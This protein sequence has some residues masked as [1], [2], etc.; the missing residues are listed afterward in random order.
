MGNFSYLV[1]DTSSVAINKDTL[2]KFRYLRNK[3]L[4]T[5]GESWP[6]SR[7]ADEVNFS[8]SRFCNIYKEIYKISPTKDLI[9]EKI[10][11]AKN[12]LS[13]GDLS[14]G[15]I[16]NSLGYDNQTHFSRQFKSITGYSPALYREKF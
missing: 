3:M 1:N 6:I 4:S 13:Y 16:S 8:Q 5:I 14:I 15:E 12:M 9:N 11:M 10:N 2:L 7:M